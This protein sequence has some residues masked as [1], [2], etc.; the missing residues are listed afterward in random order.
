MIAWLLPGDPCS[1]IFPLFFSFLQG[2]C[3]SVKCTLAPFLTLLFLT[4][5]L[6]SVSQC[7]LL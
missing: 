3:F 7:H 1:W 6:A 5:L 2:C 4:V